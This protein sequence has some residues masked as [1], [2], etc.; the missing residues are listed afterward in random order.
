MVIEEFQNSVPE[1]IRIYLS[2]KK[3]GTVREL[4]VMADEY[5][6][7]YMSGRQKPPPS[8][9]PIRASIR[10]TEN[11]RRIGKSWEYPCR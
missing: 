5:T 1:E 4:A 8:T 10:E 2:E 3:R 11:R 6:I 9:T 7:T